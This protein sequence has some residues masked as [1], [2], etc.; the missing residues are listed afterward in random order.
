MQLRKNLLS[1]SRH[2]IAASPALQVFGQLVS[3]LVT[4]LD[5]GSGSDVVVRIEATRLIEQ[6][7]LQPSFQAD[8][9]LPV[10]VPIFE[11]LCSL[12]TN[13]DE[14]EMQAPVVRLMGALVDTLGVKLRLLL[15]P[16][17]WHL[18]V[19]WQASDSNSPVRCCILDALTK[20]VKTSG[21]ASASLHGLA[22][23]L[24]ASACSGEDATA[25]LSGDGVALCLAV[26][27]NLPSP[28]AYCEA[29]DALLPLC[30]RCLFL[31]LGGDEDNESGS[32]LRARSP[33]DD[34]RRVMLICEAY[35]ITDG[36]RVL[37][38]NAA[39]LSE[40]L[41]RLIGAVKATLV[42]YIAR[43]IEALF[44]SCPTDAGR[45]LQQSGA[46]HSILRTCVA[47]V[48]QFASVASLGEH[49]EEDV[50]LVSYLSIFARMLLTDA[51]QIMP[52]ARSI[53]AECLAADAAGSLTGLD[54][55]ILVKCLVRLMIDKF[56]A[57]GS[58][59][60]G[61]WRRRL[62]CLSLLSL[63]PHT[64]IV[65]EWFPEVY[66]IAVDVLAEDATEEGQRRKD[67]LLQAL[68]GGDGD[69]AGC[70][71]DDD[72]DE[73]NGRAAAADEPEPITETFGR[74]LSADVV[75]ASDVQAV[76]QA[77]VQA[78]QTIGP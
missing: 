29:L 76:M 3:F 60:A 32:H 21:K 51:A 53:C 64:H 47:S 2:P 4:T 56:D 75:M 26:M 27:R 42:E 50:V 24:V 36:P 48:P 71:D 18:Q 31:Q 63:Y 13:L 68:M 58:C 65:A 17:A 5:K 8:L 9:L 30:V 11:S 77:K 78:M 15:E 35:A 38:A 46:L 66:N 40:A 45:F 25:H 10:I 43:P 28:D 6:I 20:M 69:M 19:L 70:N 16:L 41:Q 7:I 52:A 55:S 33:D 59:T 37:F 39:V 12:T 74:L 62:W 67:G 72:D 14:P 54:E 61:M 49:R 73:D 44:L 23:P 1:T 34:M 22:L 57:V